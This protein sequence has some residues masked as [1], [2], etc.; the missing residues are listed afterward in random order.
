MREA[1]TK[2]ALRREARTARENLPETDRGVWS[3]RIRK[4]LASL[5][6]WKRARV[7][8][9]Y[10]PI[11][12][13]VDLLPLVE[14]A[15]AE[16]KRVIFPRARVEG[17]ALEFFEIRRPEDLVPGAYGVPEPPGEGARR[18]PLSAVDLV[19]LPGLAFDARGRRLGFGGGYYD[20]LLERGGPVTVGVAFDCQLREALPEEAHDRPVEL[21]LT[22]ARCLA[23]GG[24]GG[25]GGT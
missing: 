6:V 3:E 4:R 21:V 17:R 23:P 16:G 8:A 13:E 20:R 19:V 18:V 2:A 25:E 7:V 22:E 12:G 5:P 15:R 9:L 11:R 10:A 24:I 14:L 1:E